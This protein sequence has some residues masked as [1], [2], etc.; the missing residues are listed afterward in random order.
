[1]RNL[2]HHL[3]LAILTALLLM[4][5]Y[6]C[7]DEPSIKHHS[8]HDDPTPADTTTHGSD[9]TS[10]GDT[11]TVDTTAVDTTHTGGGGGDTTTIFTLSIQAPRN[12]GYMGQT[13]Q[14]T[15]VTSS[16]ASVT[17][18]SSSPTVAF[19]E[20][21]GMVTFNN[22]ITDGSSL[23]TATAAG[24]S[25]SIRLTNRRWQ[26]A[27]WDGNSWKAPPYLTVHQGDTL[28]VT[29]AD[30]ELLAIDDQ[31]FNAAACQ[32][33][34][35]SYNTE[36]N[37]ITPIASSESTRRRYVISPNAPIGAT[38]TLLARYGEVASMLSGTVTR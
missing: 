37:I 8:N 28:V 14:L 7:G 31:G 5:A 35:S 27:A 36:G 1:M 23:I 26:V 24:V 3:P 30:S 34:A 6:A 25:D 2:L 9:T 15:A 38:V 13:L 21:D 19:I 33:T 20:Q 10:H 22:T 32:W 4:G 29:I 16:P 18:H 17:W 12:Y 11:T